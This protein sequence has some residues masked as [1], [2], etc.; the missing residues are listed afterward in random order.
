LVRLEAECVCVHMKGAFAPQSVPKL[1]PHFVR[2]VD[3]G[4]SAV[5]S[6]H[7]HEPASSVGPATSEKCQFRKL[8]SYRLRQ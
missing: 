1:F 8:A 7:P 4:M 5:S 3:F 6:L 2:S